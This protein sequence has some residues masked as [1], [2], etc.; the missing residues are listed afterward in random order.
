[1]KK[2]LLTRFWKKVNIKKP[3]DC[4][5]WKN[6]KNKAGYGG[7]QNSNKSVNAHRFAWF[8]AHGKIT[9]NLYVCHICDVK[10]CVNPAHLFLGT[11]KDN[12]RDSM[13]K[14]RLSKGS[15]HHAA[16]LDENKVRK[17]RE[18]RKTGLIFREL[19]KRFGVTYAAAYYAI[20]GVTWK[21]VA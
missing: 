10:S 14:G 17:M 4:W 15:N 18:L 16:K 5:L 1:M 3:E 7:F 20:S 12:I 13:K 2:N 6:C 19:A 8:L 9:K 11:Q 21:S